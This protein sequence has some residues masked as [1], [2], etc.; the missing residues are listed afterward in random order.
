MIE[1]KDAEKE[2]LI[3]EIV[4]LKAENLILKKRLKECD[5]A[6]KSIVLMLNEFVDKI[7]TKIEGDHNGI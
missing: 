3:N 1:V 5:S 4:Q 2:V 7:K 6:L